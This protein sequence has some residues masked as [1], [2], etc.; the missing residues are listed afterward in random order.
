MAVTGYFV[1]DTASTIGLTD[2]K[3]SLDTD[4]SQGVNAA[5]IFTAIPPGV[6]GNSIKVAQV[7][8]ADDNAAHPLSIS[9][10]RV[11][12]FD[13][14]TISLEVDTDGS[15]ILTIASEI[16]AIVESDPDA[17]R[18]VSVA[19]KAANNGTGVA[20]A[21]AAAALTGGTKD[22]ILPGE[23]RKVTAMAD[24][25]AILLVNGGASFIPAA[26]YDRRR[27]IARLIKYGAVDESAQ[28]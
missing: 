17:S 14:I 8:P 24:A 1:N 7:V 19:N 25:D 23:I 18:L 13:V 9:V 27:A 16:E 10:D 12:E 2:T 20:A 15:T 3:A 22:D 4:G 26:G 11:G 5:L 6:R 21:F 28:S